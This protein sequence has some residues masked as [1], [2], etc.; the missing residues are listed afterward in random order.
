V[1]SVTEIS[2]A[3]LSVEVR[4]SSLVE[5][6]NVRDVPRARYLVRTKQKMW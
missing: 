3:R 5:A 6:R 2:G 4:F 1:R